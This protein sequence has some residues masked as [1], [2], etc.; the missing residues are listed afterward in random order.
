MAVNMMWIDL[1]AVT[2]ARLSIDQPP[3]F[4]GVEVLE[5]DSPEY[6]LL[7]DFVLPKTTAR[8]SRQRGR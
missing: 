7:V 4:A 6:R 5:T 2:P 3:H 8:N 1:I